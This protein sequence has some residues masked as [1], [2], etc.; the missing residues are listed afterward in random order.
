MRWL[1]VSGIWLAACGPRTVLGQGVRV[2]DSGGEARTEGRTDERINSATA[3]A[4]NEVSAAHV[5][6]V[7]M[8]GGVVIS[9]LPAPHRVAAA[10]VAAPETPQ[11]ARAMVGMRDPRDGVRFALDVAAALV[12]KP[13]IGDA[14]DGVAFVRW[15]QAQGRWAPLVPGTKPAEGT[16]ETGDVVVIDGPEI[17]LGV[18]LGTDE[19]GVS[20]LLYLGRGVVRRG[21]LDT[22][23]PRMARD[24]EGRVVNS[25]VRHGSSYPPAGTRYLAGE[26]AS[27]RVRFR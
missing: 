21:H 5:G 3:V 18:V 26:L 20:D 9:R 11:A 1:I 15:A 8:D 25:Y 2:P 7:G 24:R 16:L 27:G 22:A 23:R 13:V 10:I 4:P 17:T 6:A 12:G 14:A 19:R